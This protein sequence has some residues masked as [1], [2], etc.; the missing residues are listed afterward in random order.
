MVQKCSHMKANTWC[1][2]LKHD[3]NVLPNQVICTNYITPMS[4]VDR[5]IDEI[6]LSKFVSCC[7]FRLENN[8][9]YCG[10]VRLARKGEMCKE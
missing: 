2:L 5:L 7:D 1:E 8:A 4:E 6:R 10:L 9:H 3:C